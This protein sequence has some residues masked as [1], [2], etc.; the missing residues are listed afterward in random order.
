MLA[1]LSPAKDME[2]F[3]F[4]FQDVVQFSEPQ[5]LDKSARLVEELNRLNPSEFEQIM[6][7]SQKLAHLNINRLL[8]WQ[9]HHTVKNSM[10][11]ILA[12]TG[13]V[14]RGLRSSEMRLDDLLYS[15]NVLRILSGLYGSLRPF[16][17]IQEYRLE[18][19]LKYN[20]SIGKNLYE[21]WREDITNEL[22]KAIANSPGDKVL[23]N[24]AS[25]EYS[26]AI[27]LE[28][29][30]YPVVTASFFEERQGKLKMVTV[31]AKKARGTMARFII[32]NRIEN[33]EDISAFY[34]DGYY[35]DNVR[36]TEKELVFVR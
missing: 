11:S 6:A 17:L 8:R 28:K 27:D 1:I 14:Y 23:V 32:E 24:L 34:S 18:M 36:S 35:F 29:L 13:E 9:R 10:P 5:F 4:E 15:Q 20:F 33:I 12:F 25:K 2:V 30:N 7:V 22:N 26:S 21:I 3:P 19:G 16:D 31:Y